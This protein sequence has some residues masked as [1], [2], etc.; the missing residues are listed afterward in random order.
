M[1]PFEIEGVESQRLGSRKARTLLKILALARSKPVAV[2][3]LVECLWPEAM[4][5]KPATQVAV[6]V[7]RLRAVLGVDRLV[8]SDAGYALLTD[9]LDIEAVAQLGEEAARR[10]S[11][12]SYT[13]A[14]TAASAALSLARGALLE[15]EPDALWAEPDR[16]AA[17]RLFSRVRHTA[18]EAALATEAW[19]DAAELGR[20]ALDVDPYDEVALRVI[21]AALTPP[22]GRPPP[23]PHTPSSGRVSV[24]TWGSVRAPRPRPSIRPSC[25]SNPSTSQLLNPYR[26]NPLPG[27]TAPGRPCTGGPASWRR[28]IPHWLVPPTEWNCW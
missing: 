9:W 4:P 16:A 11:M 27:P 19:A 1:G 24:R 23:S 17:A 25:W 6:L 13:L 5:A 7:S 8:R 28:W 18:A 21:M 3:L 14:R 22:A 12:G 2:D 20:Q 10:A 26:P 15:D